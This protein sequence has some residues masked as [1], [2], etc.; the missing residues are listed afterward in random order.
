MSVPEGAAFRGERGDGRGGRH[1]SAYVQA[2][3]DRANRVV[4]KAFERQRRGLDEGAPASHDRYPLSRETEAIS[5]AELCA[6]LR[7]A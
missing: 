4:R 3:T 5:V 2:E 6:L 7:G 1:E